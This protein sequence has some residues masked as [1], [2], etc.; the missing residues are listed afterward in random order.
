MRREMKTI[1]KE[2]DR[3][4]LKDRKRLTDTEQKVLESISA[5]QR[6]HGYAPTVRELCPLVGLSSTSSV[7]AHLMALEKKGFLERKASSPRAML[8]L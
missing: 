3:I 7:A 6:R 1:M 4:S 2:K 5:Y 8:I